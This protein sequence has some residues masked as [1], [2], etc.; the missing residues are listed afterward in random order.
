[1]GR[2]RRKT[3]GAAVKAPET[4]QDTQEQQ[5]MS[6]DTQGQET[7]SEAAQEAAE[8]G[9]AAQ[10]IIG[11]EDPA[12]LLGCEDADEAELVE[13]LYVEYAVTSKGG[14]RLREAPGVESPIIA[15][16]PQGAGVFGDGVPGPDG[17]FHV[18]TGHLEGWM[19]AKYL[20]ALSWPELSNVV[21]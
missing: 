13:G 11:P 3:E 19:M 15:V 5:D 14:L 16:L 6:Q 10:E 17:W 2:T 18:R 7:A 21:G 8:G 9:Q 4:A 1:M 20:E 12:D